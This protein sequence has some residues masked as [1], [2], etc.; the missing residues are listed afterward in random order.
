MTLALALLVLRIAVG[1]LLVGHGAQK[2]FGLFGGPGLQGTTGWLAS[3]GLRPARLWAFAAAGSE[4]GG[5]LLIA[6]G[7]L[8]PLGAL[9]VIAAMLMAIL[10]VHRSNGLWASSGGIEYNLVLIAASTALLLA[11]AGRLSFDALLGLALPT[12]VVAA[13]AALAFAGVAAALGSR[14]APATA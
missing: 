12:P 7:L 1:G 14:R 13:A 6:L 9:A 10:L 4:L 5:G 8:T 2:L 3:L 11:G